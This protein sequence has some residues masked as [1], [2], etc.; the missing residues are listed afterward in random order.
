ME[1][2]IFPGTPSFIHKSKDIHCMY[3]CVCLGRAGSKEID[4]DHN[5]VLKIIYIFY[6]NPI[7]GFENQPIKRMFRLNLPYPLIGGE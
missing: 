2:P 6:T 3:V 7:K 4:E 5:F 1:F